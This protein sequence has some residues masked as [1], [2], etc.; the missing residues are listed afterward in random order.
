LTLLFEGIKTLWI[1]S[2]DK[3]A[4]V[5][6]LESNEYL[7]RCTLGAITSLFSPF[8]CTSFLLPW[9]FF[10]A[11]PHFAFI[12][13]QSIA[14]PVAIRIN[15]TVAKTR[16]LGFTRLQMI[17]LIPFG[18]RVTFMIFSSDFSSQSPQNIR[19]YFFLFLTDSDIW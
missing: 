7:H 13:F 17:Q 15:L 3:I 12:L 16:S 18:F 5:K 11:K 9:F 10:M 2:P 19:L 14:Y 4:P 6:I 1:M 8:M